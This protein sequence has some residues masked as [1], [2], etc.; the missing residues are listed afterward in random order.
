MLSLGP[1]TASS[2]HLDRA[3]Q[4]LARNRRRRR[5]VSL[6]T[7]GLP[8]PRGRAFE[9][10]R[11][12]SQ[13]V[14]DLRGVTTLIDRQP[15]LHT[16]LLGFSASASFRAVGAPRGVAETAVLLGSERLRALTWGCALA[17]FAAQR[18][19]LATMRAFWQHSILTALLAEKIAREA[20]PEAA[21]RAY[22][23]GLLHDIGR[24]PLLVALQEQDPETEG[25]SFSAH[26][27][28][29]AER[30]YFGL[31]HAELGRWIALSGSLSAWL[32]D[33]LAHHHD[34]ACACDDPSLA[35]IVA[36]ADRASQPYSVAES[37]HPVAERAAQE[38]LDLRR[39]RHLAGQ[40]RA[41]QSSFLKRA[42]NAAPL[43]L[44]CC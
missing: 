41:A 33:A 36:A 34:P 22:L 27:E 3:A 8:L 9:L 16:Q 13:P 14:L 35:A 10:L 38:L 30:R 31:D 17:E 28:P 19:P 15:L 39:P 23:A 25:G 24:L 44:G 18:L 7:A 37:A 5:V 4:I 32:R 1:R 42:G 43:R 20:Q 6:L 26:D 40:Q 12:L 21:E 2:D 29:A 11:L